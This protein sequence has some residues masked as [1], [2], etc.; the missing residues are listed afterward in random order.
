[1]LI[2]RCLVFAACCHPLLVLGLSQRYLCGLSLH[3][4]IHTPAVFMLHLLVSSHKASAFPKKTMGRHYTLSFTA[5]S[6]KG[7]FSGLQSFSNVEACKF[8]C[9]SD[10]SYLFLSFRF[11]FFPQGIVVVLVLGFCGL[12]ITFVMGLSQTPMTFF[13]SLPNII[14]SRGFYFRAIR[15]LLPPHASDMLTA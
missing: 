1:M 8:A 14:G 10:R 12:S 4:S 7:E 13:T 3:A 5:T 9:H 15:G 2:A 6:V 11:F